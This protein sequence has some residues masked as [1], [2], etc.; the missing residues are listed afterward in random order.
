MGYLNIAAFLLLPSVLATAAAGPQPREPLWTF[1]SNASV[2][3]C[4]STVAV[5][6]S[7]S[8]VFAADATRI[9]KLDGKTGKL[10]WSKAAA[11]DEDGSFS[12]SLAATRDNR[13][14][15]VLPTASFLL[16]LQAS[17]GTELWKVAAA[18]DRP[19][20]GTASFT[21][22]G[23]TVFATGSCGGSA[24]GV[25][26][27]VDTATGETRWTFDVPQDDTTLPNGYDQGNTGCTKV[28]QSA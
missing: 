2:L 18:N 20:D 21:S 28:G 26:V 17:D 13:T 16:R 6:T 23:A 14:I 10:E 4:E 11:N 25:V 5:D 1:R 12:P 22:D 9:Y 15:V 3:P 7:N 24:K 27:A 8:D 19:F